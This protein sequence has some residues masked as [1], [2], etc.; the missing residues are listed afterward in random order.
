[1]R[2]LQVSPNDGRGG[3][4]RIAL[5]LHRAY[6][7]AGHD[8]ALVVGRRLTGEPGVEPLD[9]TGRPAPRQGYISRLLGHDPPGHPATARLTDRFAPPPDVLHLNNLHGGGDPAGGGSYFDLRQLPRLSRQQA[10][11]LTPHD[12]WLFTGGPTYALHPPTRR[13][14]RRLARRAA[15]FANSELH[16]VC[17]SQ[18]ML[19]QAMASPLGPHFRS[20]RVIPVG[21]DLT[22]FHPGSPGNSGN[23]ADRAADRA[24]FGLDDRPAALFV[25]HDAHRHPFKDFQTV[26]D[27]AARS[28]HRFTLIVAGTAGTTE[29]LNRCTVRY[30][31]SVADDAQLVA[32]YHAADVLVHAA[33][34]D[35]FPNVILEA[36]ACGL[37][38]V[39]TA[40]GG[41]PEQVADHE[42]GRLVPPRDPD[43]LTDA[44]DA[45]LDDPGRAARMGA[46]A[47]RRA[48]THHDLTARAAE[49]LSHYA[50]QHSA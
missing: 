11:F 15:I 37:P 8:A 31:G 40:V 12:A 28:R 36:M 42:T 25:A 39:A 16:L 27:A 22:T 34:A 2:I 1:M 43:A 45:M 23:C 19:K 29:T 50:A 14:R 26:R 33:V 9:F 46:A 7:A 6:R 41:I 30:L 10:T 47:R 21:V 20:A 35:N 18:W 38:V 3:A 49:N 5:D 48:E 4:E 24:A 17:S 32:A 44:V 13:Q